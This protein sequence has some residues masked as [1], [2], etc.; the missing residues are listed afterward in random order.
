M[1]LKMKAFLIV[2]LVVLVTSCSED[3]TILNP[4][5]ERNVE[6]FYQTETDF[7]VAINGAYAT[8][9]GNGAYNRAYPLLEEMRS[10]NTQNGGG[11]TGLAE[12]YFRLAFFE[13]V[14]TASELSDPWTTAYQG[15]ARANL[16]LDRLD[17]LSDADLAEQIRGE[18]L[19]IRSIFYYH[20][21]ILWGNVPLQLEAVSS[22]SVDV[23]Q[24]S[25]SVI[26]DQIASDLEIAQGLLPASYAAEDLGR[27]TGG[28]ANALLGLAY[29][30]DGEDALAATALQ[31]V[32][33]SG[34]YSLVPNYADLWGAA[35][36]NNVESVFEIQYKEGGT[37]TGSQF[38]DY[39]TP[40]GGSGGVGAGNAPQNLSPGLED[41]HLIQYGIA[42]TDERGMGGTFDLSG[43]GGVY[44]KKWESIPFGPGDADNNMPVF[45]YAD[46]LLMLAE[47]LGDSPAAYALIN[48]V[49]A[50][51]GVTPISA[52][53]TGTFDEKLLFERRLEFITELKRWADLT[54]F[55]VAKQVMAAF[56][57]L[58]TA[59][60]TE[61]DIRLFFLIPQREIDVA[62]N[63][64]TQNPL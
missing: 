41:I 59:G 20:L 16:I 64:M 2:P 38:T 3:F 63:S 54:R 23:N 46:V 8:L 57:P 40:F 28:A 48:Q 18:A 43:T 21:A 5:S 52:A 33:D 13:E 1:K 56:A 7:I 4:I 36:E 19:F 53:T 24:V 26:F 39:Y 58:A 55:G 62:P 50:R 30:T 9:A 11:S 12:V 6:N 47:A 42:E 10:D 49:R 35:N 60:K 25:A 15:I 37:G 31:R 45:R 22:T 61:A 44:V 14:A 17:N 29:L 27:A 34:L 51:A 32:V